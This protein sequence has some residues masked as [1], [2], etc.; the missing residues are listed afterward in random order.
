MKQ[1]FALTCALVFVASS[2]QGSTVSEVYNACTQHNKGCQDYFAG[3]SDGMLSYSAI[4]KG[5]AF[6]CTAKEIST[7]EAGE[8]FVN[9]INADAKLKTAPNAGIA[10]AIILQ[11][12]FPCTGKQ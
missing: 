8:L 7:R 2:A 3:F 5:M 1:M 11:K 6:F 4:T 12:N 10:Y 9:G